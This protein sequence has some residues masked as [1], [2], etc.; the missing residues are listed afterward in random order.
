[1][2]N[3]KERTRRGLG[4]RNM[5]GV[6]DGNQKENGRPD[7]NENGAEI[8]AGMETE[9]GTGTTGGWGRNGDE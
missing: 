3:A 1:M 7:C 4:D 6:E 5:V 9:M 2:N 8:E